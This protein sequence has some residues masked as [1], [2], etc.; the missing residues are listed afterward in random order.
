M[1]LQCC[2]NVST[3][4]VLY[5]SN[6]SRNINCAALTG[7]QRGPSCWPPSRR[8]LTLVVARPGK[9][10]RAA[11][12]GGWVVSSGRVANCF[13]DL[14]GFFFCFS[15]SD[16]SSRTTCSMSLLLL[17]EYLVHCSYVFPKMV[18]CFYCTGVNLSTLP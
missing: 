13:A 8:D 5:I 2:N 4:F 17:L 14:R 6:I 1:Y 16:A 12:G 7:V 10:A 18:K 15:D 3:M 11:F 9:K